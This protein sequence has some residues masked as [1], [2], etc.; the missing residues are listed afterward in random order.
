MSQL[1]VAAFNLRYFRK[2]KVKVMRK[3]LFSA[4]SF[5]FLRL[6]LREIVKNYLSHIYNFSLMKKI[7]VKI[8]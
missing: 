3:Y 2:G 7:R 8:K 4:Y 6:G 5:S 1:G